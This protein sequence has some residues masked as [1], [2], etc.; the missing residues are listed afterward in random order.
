MNETSVG[1]CF[2]DIMNIKQKPMS[3][4]QGSSRLA[5]TILV[6]DEA[7]IIGENIRFHATQGI[8]CFIVMDNGSVDGTREILEEFRDEVELEI[9]ENPRHTIDQDLWV[10]QMAQYLRESG[11]ADWVIHNDADEFWVNDYGSLKSEIRQ[12]MGVLHVPRQNLL[13]RATD[14]VAPGYRFFHN[15][16][17]VANPLGGSNQVVN[18]DEPLEVEMKLRKIPGK[19]MCSLKGLHSVGMGNHTVLHDA[20]LHDGEVS[21]TDNTLIYHF[22]VRSY[23]QFV[24]KVRNYGTALN[25][26]TRFSPQTSWHL[27]R[28]YKLY[29]R[30]QLEEEYENML[31]SSEQEIELE[32]KGILVRDETLLSYHL[33]TS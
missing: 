15:I 3:L 13:P 21:T 12:E 17:R 29:E 26:N 14:I 27:R 20:I 24:S 2:K 11:R 19:V 9:I 32:N 10:T 33:H 7:D 6:R 4:I 28:W 22:P 23:E 5:M 8:D 30:G 16:M 18:P 1:F 25:A 31:V